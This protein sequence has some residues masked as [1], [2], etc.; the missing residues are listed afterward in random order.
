MCDD[1]QETCVLCERHVL[2][3]CSVLILLSYVYIGKDMKKLA[4][5]QMK[6]LKVLNFW[7]F[8]SGSGV[9]GSLTVTV[10]ENL[11]DRAWGT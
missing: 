1:L 9:G 8:T 7:K 6:Y 3:L 11:Y 2:Y 4:Y 10:A 5:E